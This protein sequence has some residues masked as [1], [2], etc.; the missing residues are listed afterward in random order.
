MQNTYNGAPID[1]RFMASVLTGGT[2]SLPARGFDAQRYLAA[3]PDVR[4]AGV[5]PYEHYLIHGW[6]EGRVW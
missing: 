5:N 3:N 2:A 6:C 4:A 1:E